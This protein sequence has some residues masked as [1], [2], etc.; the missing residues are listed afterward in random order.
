MICKIN[1]IIMYFEENKIV[2]LEVYLEDL[3]FEPILKQDPF[4]PY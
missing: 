4:L 3:N 2:T 1:D